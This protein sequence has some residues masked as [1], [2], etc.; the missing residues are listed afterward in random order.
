MGEAIARGRADGLDH[1][2]T[3]SRL[4][5]VQPRELLL[6]HL[7]EEIQ[8]ELGTH[9]RRELD[10]VCRL[11]GQRGEAAAD[12]LAH[13][14]RRGDLLQRAPQPN[15]SSVQLD[16]VSVDERPPQ[17]AEEEGIA[18]SEIAERDGEAGRGDA[19]GHSG[20][21]EVGHVLDEEPREMQRHGV[22]G[23]AKVGDV[24]PRA[25]PGLPPR[26]RGTLPRS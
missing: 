5:R 6:C 21:D 4:E 23:A 16:R 11:L 1:S 22:A 14:V 8:S 2:G 9:D 17:L 20:G 13:A 18:T 15:P 12:D 26:C 3:L 24:H 19:V 7:S 25:E 10:E